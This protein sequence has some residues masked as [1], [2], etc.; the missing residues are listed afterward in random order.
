MKKIIRTVF[1]LALFSSASVAWAAEAGNDEAIT[2]ADVA[3]AFKP[4]F[5]PYAGRNYPTRVLFGDTHL[6]TAV[7]V[8][9][10]TMNR[11]GQ[12]DAFRF[13]RGEEV[14]TTGGL[15]AKLVAAA[16]FP[17]HL[18]SR[19]DVW[20]DAAIAQR[21][22]RKCSP[23]ETGKKWYERVESGN[24]DTI[25]ATA[26]EIV[27]S[28]SGDVP[29]IKS[30]KAVRN[31]WQAYTALADKYN[32]PGTV[33]RDH[34]LR[35]DRDRRLQSP[36]Q[37]DLP[38]QC[39]R[40]Q[41]YHPVLAIRQQE[42]G[43]S[44]EVSRR[45][46]EADRRR[47]VGHS[48]QRQPQQRPHVHRRDIRRQAAHQGNGGARARFEPLI[49]VTQ[50]KG[51][52]ESHPFLSPNDEFAGYEKWDR[53]NL[54][55]TEAKKPE[56]LQCEYAREALKTG[57]MLGK[58]A[59]REPL[60]VRHGRQHRFPHLLVYGRRG[61]LL[62]QALRRRARAASLGARRH[63][64]ARSEVHH[65]GLAAGC[66]RVTPPFGRRRTRARRSSTPCSARKPTPP[67]AR[68]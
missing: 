23:R 30:D 38:R 59:R 31:A 36:P 52:G 20:P 24:H 25:F 53:S 37:R 61:Q 16:R 66:Q 46:R 14:T 55:G 68:A 64:S 49:E 9:A 15:R 54:N 21:R 33:H 4:E 17:G 56:M 51:D 40:G 32:E 43:R 57:L 10:G 29:P 35:V 12:E 8:D 44:L 58:Q 13:A 45:V 42:S 67:P 11:V 19:R 6:H 34:R 50:I 47:G 41:P 26:M 39:E 18:R 27:G 60:Q 65:Q 63:R 48:P 2:K 62:R 3:D 22:S 1:V 7:S 28:L 5:S